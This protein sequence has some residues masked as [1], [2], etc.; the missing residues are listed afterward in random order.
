MS[1]K[2]RN[3]SEEGDSI[4]DFSNHFPALFKELNE[5]EMELREEEM[6]TA[7]GIKK[8]RKFQGY[9]PG[10]VDFICRC[11]TEEEAIE[12]INYLLRKGDISEDYAKS[13]IKQFMIAKLS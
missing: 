12:I 4:E 5:G 6:R 1:K 8:V 9:I 2:N 3:S 7:T 11:K 13:L 10:V